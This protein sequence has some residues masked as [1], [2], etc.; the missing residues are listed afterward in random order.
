MNTS[1][2]SGARFHGTPAEMAGLALII[3]VGLTTVFLAGP[4]FVANDGAQY[5][6]TI[7]QI[8]TG[9]GIRT[10][11]IYYEVQAQFGMPAL[12]TVWPPGLPLLAAGVS[13]ITGLS[14]LHSV[15]LLSAVAHCGT[16]LLMYWLCSRLL[17]GDRSNGV[18]IA[19]SYAF[20][21]PALVLTIQVLS[22]PLFTASLV[23]SASLLHAGLTCRSERERIALFAGASLCV[24]L[25]CTFRYLGVAFVGALGAVGCLQLL[26]GRLSPA[27]IRA[28]IALVVPA[29][30]VVALMLVRNYVMTGRLTGGPEGPR[31]LEFG[32][33]SQQLRWAIQVLLGDTRFWYGKLLVLFLIVGAGGWAAK[34][35]SAQDWSA[36]VRRDERFGVA[37]FA[38]VGS[39]ATVALLL[40]MSLRKTGLMVEARYLVP[41]VPLMLICIAALWPCEKSSAASVGVNK[42]WYGAAVASVA[43]VSVGY[44]A[45]MANFVRDG[46]Y[47]ARLEAILSQKVGNTSARDLLR[48]A[49]SMHSPVMSNQSQA[50]HVVLRRPTLGIA[51]RRITPR[52]WSTDDVRLQAKNFGVEYVVVFPTLPL[53]NPEADEDYVLRAA[54]SGAMG[55]ETVHRSADLHILKSVQV[56]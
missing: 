47:P 6:S 29:V 31:A 33:I 56:R 53:G 17:D 48:A 52:V 18:I 37:I 45:S 42:L 49:A 36:Y 46:A 1:V 3:G 39:A 32:E 44:F 7:D 30:L 28:G 23:A 21:V 43:L 2:G 4:G 25:A 24:G 54:K 15:A 14:G 10:S 22:E 8:L 35:L 16:A 27:S 40:M 20:Y 12:Q 9:N 19:V 50:L 38:F 26:R 11:T 51:E 13:L 41:C 34:R 55:F 5:L